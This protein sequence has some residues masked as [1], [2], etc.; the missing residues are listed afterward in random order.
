MGKRIA[1][2]LIL[3]S[4]LSP[5][6][7]ALLAPGVAGVPAA[8]SATPGLAPGGGL[9]MASAAMRGV[10]ATGAPRRPGRMHRLAA[11]LGRLGAAL[12]SVRPQE[13]ALASAIGADKTEETR[14][15]EERLGRRRREPQVVLRRV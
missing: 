5:A 4:F 10:L 11:V 14:E 9:P 1:I 6:L 13:T 3:L 12:D 2:L 15:Y 7:P 8:R